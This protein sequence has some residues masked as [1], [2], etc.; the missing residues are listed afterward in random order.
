MHFF[1]INIYLPKIILFGAQTST[2]LFLN[3]LITQWYW[4][5]SAVVHVCPA[6]ILLQFFL[7][8]AMSHA[9]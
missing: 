7:W 6:A 8:A 9:S 2:N 4:N 5:L 3:P 1:F